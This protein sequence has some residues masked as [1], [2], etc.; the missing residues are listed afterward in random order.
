MEA[1]V[2][3]GDQS[4][5]AEHK[6]WSQAGV[7]G[8]ALVIASASVLVDPILVRFVWPGLR[9]FVSINVSV[10]LGMLKLPGVTLTPV[11]SIALPLVLWGLF[12]LP[13]RH[14]GDSRMWREC[15]DCLARTVTFLVLIFVVAV[16]GE[17]LAV[18]VE[19]VV[20]EIKELNVAARVS[21][22]VNSPL[23]D[24]P[25]EMT[26]RFIGLLGMLTVAG[27]YV[28]RVIL[29]PVGGYL[30]RA[31]PQHRARAGGSK[32]TPVRMPVDRRPRA[33]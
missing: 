13:W 11:F 21:M 5:K 26:I 24:T 3:N 17:A 29:K 32:P 25:G 6:G 15:F 2:S 30:A 28:R 33:K 31:W 8:V 18:M 12:L 19:A 22:S 10:S 1:L 4:E 9:D 23:S 20:P 27:G 16:F 7:L 14:A